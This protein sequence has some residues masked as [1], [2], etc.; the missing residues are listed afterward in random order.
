MLLKLLEWSDVCGDVRGD[1]TAGR[2][3]KEG[4]LEIFDFGYM[5]GVAEMECN[6][7]YKG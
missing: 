5:A 2:Q 6:N 3:G 4:K 7:F 1:V